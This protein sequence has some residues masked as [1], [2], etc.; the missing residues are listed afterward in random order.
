MMSTGEEEEPA[1]SPHA[2]TLRVTAPAPVLQKQRE[3]WLL[4]TTSSALLLDQELKEVSLEDLRLFAREVSA[5]LGPEVLPL[6]TE[7]LSALAEEAV[8][9]LTPGVQAGLSALD[10]EHWTL[11][12][13]HGDELEA[14]GLLRYEGR[15]LPLRLLVSVTPSAEDGTTLHAGPRAARGQALARMRSSAPLELRA[16]VPLHAVRP[17][18]SLGPSARPLVRMGP[19]GLPFFLMALG[20][21]LLCA[22]VATL[23][24]TDRVELHYLL[25]DLS[26]TDEPQDQAGSSS[27]RRIL[28]LCFLPAPGAGSE[29]AFAAL[30]E[31]HLLVGEIHQD[32]TLWGRA[33]VPLPPALAVLAA[34]PDARAEMETH[35]QQIVA[36]VALR[37][38]GDSAHAP[39]A[40]S[41]EWRPF[42]T[43]PEHL[44]LLWTC[45]LEASC[46][47]DDA[48]RSGPLREGP[49]SARVSA[50]AGCPAPLLRAR[51]P[52]RVGTLRQAGETLSADALTPQPDGREDAAQYFEPLEDGFVFSD[53]R[54]V[55]RPDTRGVEQLFWVP[56]RMEGLSTESVDGRLHFQPTA[57]RDR[58]TYASGARRGERSRVTIAS[59]GPDA[60]KVTETDGDDSLL[61][62]QTVAR[63]LTIPDWSGARA[64][65][66]SVSFAQDAVF[67]VADNYDARVVHPPDKAGTIL[68]VP[69]LCLRGQPVACRYKRKQVG[70][71]RL[72]GAA[73][74]GLS[75][76]PNCL[77]LLP[78]ESGGL[79]VAVDC[80]LHIPVGDATALPVAAAAARAQ[81]LGVSPSAGR[82]AGILS[83]VSEPSGIADTLDTSASRWRD[84]RD[85]VPPGQQL[86]L[87]P[88]AAR[89][90]LVWLL[91]DSAE[92]EDTTL[93][94]LTSSLRSS[95]P[96][97]AYDNRRELSRNWSTVV[98]AAEPQTT[99]RGLAFLG[100]KLLLSD[101]RYVNANG[102]GGQGR[103]EGLPEGDSA[104]AFA[105][106]G[107]G[108][109][110]LQ[111]LQGTWA[112][113]SVTAKGVRVLHV[114]QGPWARG[115]AVKASRAQGRTHTQSPEAFVLAG[116]ELTIVSCNVAGDIRHETFSLPDAPDHVQLLS[117]GVIVCSSP[118]SLY[119]LLQRRLRLEAA[120]RHLEGTLT[121]AGT[122]KRV[123]FAE[124]V[125]ALGLE[126][127]G[128]WS[129]SAP[130]VFED[131]DTV[132]IL[133][134]RARILT[135]FLICAPEQDAARDVHHILR[136]RCT[137][138]HDAV[139]VFAVAQGGACQPAL[140]GAWDVT[141]VADAV[142][143]EW[144]G[145]ADTGGVELDPAEAFA[146]AA[147]SAASAVHV[148]RELR[149]PPVAR[150][151]VLPDA[152]CWPIT[153]L[154]RERL[155]LA[156]DRDHSVLLLFVDPL[157]STRSPV[158]LRVEAADS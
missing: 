81:R 7:E 80:F 143:G 70:S 116:T 104:L 136:A 158:L 103:V 113:A 18:A 144:L 95:S 59:S 9:L 46:A 32:G 130:T 62:L 61:G 107:S 49:R 77:R 94:S 23:A 105:C 52:T 37:D 148:P 51:P 41:T 66:V 122:G 110:L 126:R 47:P 28:A 29:A 139:L 73:A 40:R 88:A 154:S 21:E 133:G 132:V 153:A 24:P 33:A 134:E 137:P 4:G 99:L 140:A 121:Y 17:V 145:A 124:N 85:E 135:A 109:A 149:E 117:T 78:S 142:L 82:I 93:L 2:A 56:L 6:S 3:S 22:R 111:T 58:Y 11:L 151:R 57:E 138:A 150:P 147:P 141:E 123:F 67:R 157:H 83:A 119:F 106:Y 128:A 38:G 55:S 129:T 12:L 112:A 108:V 1:A 35:G 42:R 90:D 89:L 91:R 115:R 84:L 10:A 96:A 30:S 39:G 114:A 16:D 131:R 74:S 127:P 19:R 15:D 13:E 68:T 97:G 65:R 54:Y 60:G 118:H 53:D 87:S 43:E 79:A 156:R 71:A 76:V 146:R 31:T 152:S 120:P 101:A 44:P 14:E 45:T 8:E 125:V 34:L 69:G 20:S 36:A 102:L 98:P 48:Q 75:Y 92:A 26:A 63:V 100:T 72:S 50:G 86:L 5:F 25:D 27:A 155:R 64:W